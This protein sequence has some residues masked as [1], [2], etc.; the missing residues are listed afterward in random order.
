M[1]AFNQ[2]LWADISGGGVFKM[3]P[4]TMYPTTIPQQPSDFSVP[5]PPPGW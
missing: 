4:K 5:T 3:A 2:T 1:P